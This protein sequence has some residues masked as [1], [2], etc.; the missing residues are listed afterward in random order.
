M[1]AI[2]TVLTEQLQYRFFD[3]LRNRY[4]LFLKTYGAD[5][6]ADSFLGQSRF[7]GKYHL[8]VMVRYHAELFGAVRTLAFQPVTHFVVRI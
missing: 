7:F 2:F 5:M 4:L 3:K 8:S 1:N 6:T